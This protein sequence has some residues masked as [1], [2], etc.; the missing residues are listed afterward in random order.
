MLLSF[1]RHNYCDKLI[2]N[3]DILDFWRIKQHKW[4]WDDNQTKVVKEVIYLSESGVETEYVPGNHDETIRLLTRHN[5]NIGGIKIVD[6]TVHIGVDGIETLV[7]HGDLF[8]GIGDV[9]PW[10]ALLGDKAYDAI[11]RF[12]AWFNWGR[13]KLGFGYWS[14][15]KALK[16]Q[17]K[18][19]VNFIFKFESNL[20]D[21]CKKKG[22][23]RIATGHIHHA[24][25]RDIEGITYMN[26]GDW[27]ESCSALVEHHDGRWE[28]IFWTRT[29]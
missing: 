26:S 9:A 17:V 28:I 14:I 29:D 19:A 5:I 13:R 15:S 11:L 16:Q 27:V 2:L 25:I 8:D 22:Y 21:Y 24:E 4:Y 18:G 1:L 10:L 23:T 3:G 7:V 20:A 6:H 12:N